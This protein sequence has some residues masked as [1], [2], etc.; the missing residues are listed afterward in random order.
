MKEQNENNQ[1]PEK[2][3]KGFFAKYWWVILIACI[4]CIAVIYYAFVAGLLCGSTQPDS[5]GK[6]HP[7]PASMNYDIPKEENAPLEPVIDTLLG[8]NNLQVWNGIQGGIYNY[9]FFYPALPDGEVFLRCF[10]ATENVEL[11]AS[12]IR[13]ASSVEVKNH[14]DFGQIVDMQQFTIYEGDWE[15]YYAARIEVWHKNASTGEE[16]KLTEKTYRVEGWMR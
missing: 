9:S 12:R 10:E 1:T 13:T 11:S 3:K 15:E 6:D 4:I 5:F 2:K 14:T 16:T 8:D 7:I